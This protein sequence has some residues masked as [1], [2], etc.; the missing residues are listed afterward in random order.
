ML[1]FGLALPLMMLALLMFLEFGR[2]VYYY[3][4]LNNAV[5]EGARFAVVHPYND[6]EARLT[7]IREQVLGYAFGVPLQADDV[8]A[9]CEGG[10]TPNAPCQDTITVAAHIELA[11]MV[12]FT[13][14]LFGTGTTFPINGESTMQMTPFGACEAC[15]ATPTP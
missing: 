10:T 4:A 12:G 7:A 5:R 8:A 15:I 9:Y 11:P 3:A 1:E 13:T 6:N 14:R 2:I